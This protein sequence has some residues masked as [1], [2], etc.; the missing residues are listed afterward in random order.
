MAGHWQPERMWRALS[1]RGCLCDSLGSTLDWERGRK[2]Q[3]YLVLPLVEPA[4]QYC[5]RGC[6]LGHECTGQNEHEA[7]EQAWWL[8]ECQDQTL[9]GVPNIKTTADYYPINWLT[10]IE[11][12]SQFI[13]TKATGKAAHRRARH[14]PDRM[15]G[16][17]IDPHKSGCPLFPLSFSKYIY[18]VDC[19]AE[20]VQGAITGTMD[21]RVTHMLLH[22]YAQR[23]GLVI[24]AVKFEIVHFNSRGNNVPVFTLGGARLACADSFRYL[25]MLF[26]KQRNPQATAEC[27]CAPF[28][29]GC[30]RIRQFA[31][32]CNLTDRPHTMLWLTKA[33]ALPAG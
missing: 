6:H 18:D 29:A 32:E 24:N 15:A 16:N 12:Y 3:V 9:L 28:L 33:Y 26:T 8:C 27:M 11:Q 25:G 14:M 19:L 4:K 13:V 22:A 5:R 31:S 21:A 23:K 2:I 30:R 10:V 17:P 1:I 20:N 7:S